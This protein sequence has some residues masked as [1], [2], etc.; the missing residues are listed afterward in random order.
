MRKKRG[1][2]EGRRKKS[3]ISTSEAA[4]TTS[5]AR[6]RFFIQAALAKRTRESYSTAVA[7][8]KAFMKA[9]NKDHRKPA[10]RDI[11]IWIADTSLFIKADSI[12]KYLAGVRYHLGTYGTADV[13]RDTLVKRV[14]RGLFKTYGF[15]QGDDRE[16][17]TVYLL[18]RVLKS[19]DIDDH[20]ERCY[21]AASVIGFLNCLRIGEFTVSNSGDHYLRRSDWKQ[22]GERG[23]IRL[24]RCKTD[25]FGRGH[26]LKFRKMASFLDPIF[27]LGN[28]SRR[29]VVSDWH[30]DQNAPLFVLKDHSILN[31][32]RLITWFRA[33]A[34]P[35]CKDTSKLNGISFRKGGAQ[36]LREQGFS[37]EELGV[38]GRWL[39]TR[40]AAR[41]IKLTD[42]IVDRFATAFDIAAKSAGGM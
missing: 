19:V 14:V 29:H 42:P 33:K 10:P 3:I 32:R 21:A 22:E 39:T 4:S 28:Y 25:V 11:C 15:S 35:W 37:L 12:L 1:K 18:I 24:R 41:Y 26:D 34:T 8:Y 30:S 40:V 7:Q 6:A 17:I 31:R 23:S 9:R 5:V 2:K 36:A 38:L 13:A 27:W 20:D 16:P